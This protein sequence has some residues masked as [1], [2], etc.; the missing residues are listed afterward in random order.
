MNLE[1]AQSQL[2]LALSPHKHV[3]LFE[4]VN[5]RDW[6]QKCKVSKDH[7]REIQPN[8]GGVICLDCHKVVVRDLVL[9]MSTE[10][11]DINLWANT[12]AHYWGNRKAIIKPSHP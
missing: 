2:T 1:E 6:F 10:S 4:L 3:P 7:H 9:L 12:I 8:E 5:E 11:D